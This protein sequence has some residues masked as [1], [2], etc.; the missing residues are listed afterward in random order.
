MKKMF[1]VIMALVL[2]LSGSSAGLIVSSASEPKL[3]VFNMV[4]DEN[5][6]DG[7]DMVSF[8]DEYGKRNEDY[9][10]VKN[11]NDDLQQGSVSTFPPAYIPGNE[12]RVAV[13]NQGQ[14]GI[15]WS[16]SA[17]TSLGCY[18][19][20]KNG[21]SPADVD[22]SEYHLAYFGNRMSKDANDPLY[23]DGFDF[24]NP[25]NFGSNYIFSMGV[26]TRGTGPAFES[27]YPTPD[28][29]TGS[30]TVTFDESGRYDHRGGLVTGAQVLSSG[31]E[32]KNAVMSVGAVSVAITFEKEYFNFDT[33]AYFE[34]SMGT[35][36]HQVTVVG[37]DDNYSRD[38][39]NSSFR[40][41]GNGAWLAQNSWG[42][43]SGD[44]GYIWISYENGY[45][46][47]PM[48]YELS[49]A[50]K[51]DKIYQYD[52]FGYTRMMNYGSDIPQ[53]LGANV[54]TA[55]AEQHIK[56]AGFY[57]AEDNMKGTVKLY[58]LPAGYSNPTNGTLAATASYS[59]KNPGYYK[60]D[61]PSSVLLS[62]GQIFSVVVQF[63]TS[64]GDVPLIPAEQEYTVNNET[65]HAYSKARQS[66][67]GYISGTTTRW[68]SNTGT[69]GNICIKAYAKNNLSKVTWVMGSETVT[70]I[71]RPGDEIKLP[72]NIFVPDG[73][74]F[75][76]WDCT[77]PQY[78]PDEDITVTAIYSEVIKLKSKDYKAY[79]RYPSAAENAHNGT[80]GPYA[81]SAVPVLKGFKFCYYEDSYGNIYEPG[82]RLKDDNDLKPKFEKERVK[83]TL[84][85]LASYFSV[86]LLY[87]IVYSGYI[88]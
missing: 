73:Y 23:G 24:D 29:P 85:N 6:P 80:Y 83:L 79:I 35:A 65:L 10:F 39:F 9:T 54:F 18:N 58:K 71:Y 64:D 56:S 77:V 62:K 52:G 7:I 42:T 87:P 48:A 38:N 28:Y 21:A 15:C 5:S 14:A 55:D 19:I 88:I 69:D 72:Q 20:Y 25:Y 36:G 81:P 17:L 70:Q 63:E 33:G 22:Y 82:D 78:A 41:T 27:E 61:F 8:V 51:Y 46:A 30:E 1:T 57:C 12:K 34:P 76:R 3:K 75:S 49:P 13:E 60:V 43:N 47:E 45:I 44:N 50:D 86:W 32:I 67:Y 37:W 11:I 74:R 53:I 66:Y 59:F 84:S 31:D 68:G 4:V 40:P 2:A 26:L 16:Y